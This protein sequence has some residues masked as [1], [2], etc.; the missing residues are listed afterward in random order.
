MLSLPWNQELDTFSALVQSAGLDVHAD[1]A[2][3][4]NRQYG[5]SRGRTP[6]K[7]NHG[8]DRCRTRDGKNERVLVLGLDVEEPCA[9]QSSM[10]HW[11]SDEDAFK[12]PQEGFAI[13]N[14]RKT[15]PR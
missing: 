8:C 13:A 15:I 5:D 6:A 7:M 11:P 10:T 2:L 1:L 3:V 9:F 14:H 12:P 4:K